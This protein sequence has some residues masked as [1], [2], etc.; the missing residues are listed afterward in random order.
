MSLVQMKF[1]IVITIPLLSEHDSSKT[2]LPPTSPKVIV[3]PFA[4]AGVTYGNQGSAW[5]V[6]A[7]LSSSVHM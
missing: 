5:A 4:R 7:S 1:S 2:Q 6:L 3:S